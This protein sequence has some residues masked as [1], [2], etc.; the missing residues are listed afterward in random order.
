MQVKWLIRMRLDISSE[1]RGERTISAF[2]P[3]PHRLLTI[4]CTGSE[5]G[6]FNLC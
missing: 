6:Q 2:E 5:H 3:N 4:F 1:M